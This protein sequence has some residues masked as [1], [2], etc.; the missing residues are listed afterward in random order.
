MESTELIFH[1]L[2]AMIMLKTNNVDE[3]YKPDFSQFGGHAKTT[4]VDH[5]EQV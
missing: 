3:E 1:N 5:G 2:E 4:N